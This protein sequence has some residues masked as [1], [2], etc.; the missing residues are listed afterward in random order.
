MPMSPGR[1]FTVPF[2]VIATT[3]GVVDILEIQPSTS[4]RLA[5]SYLSISK[6]TMG[7]TECLAVDLVRGSTLSSTA[8]APTAITPALLD[9]RTSATATFLAWLHS[10]AAGSSG[11]AGKR[12]F[13]GKVNDNMEFIYQPY[14]DEN[15]DERPVL[16][17]VTNSTQAGIGER[18]QV[19]LSAPLAPLSVSGTM[20]LE[21]LGKA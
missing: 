4:C 2:S 13:S 16:G 19:R 7:A 21:E 15:H 5:L 11:P 12:I 18:L 10:T 20:I 3:L 1:M 9:P 17:L 8:G 14:R 6:T